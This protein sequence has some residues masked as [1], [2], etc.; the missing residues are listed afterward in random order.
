[1]IDGKNNFGLIM[2]TFVEMVD[3]FRRW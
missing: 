1:L 2:H 3:R